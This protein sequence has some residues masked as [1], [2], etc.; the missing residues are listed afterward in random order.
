MK[1]G[2]VMHRRQDRNHRNDCQTWKLLA[3]L[4][5]SIYLA[6]D[7]SMLR[8]N[9]SRICAISKSEFKLRFDYWY[10][11]Q[12]HTKWSIY[13]DLLNFPLIEKQVFTSSEMISTG[14]KTSEKFNWEFSTFSL[15][16]INFFAQVWKPASF[17]IFCWSVW[18]NSWTQLEIYFHHGKLY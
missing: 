4:N 7:L 3:W 2:Q 14:R 13:F 8:V 18:N 12:I 9:N 10:S 16:K 6:N 11:I 15:F 1:W 5:K 17:L